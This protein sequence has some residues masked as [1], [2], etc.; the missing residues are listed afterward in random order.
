MRHVDVLA[1]RSLVSPRFEILEP[2][3]KDTINPKVSRISQ[4][5]NHSFLSSP[6]EERTLLSCKVLF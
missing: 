3:A 2:I 5:K 6:K 4:V 1:E